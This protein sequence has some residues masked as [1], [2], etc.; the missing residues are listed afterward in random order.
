MI[1]FI[2]N[3]NMYVMV[4]LSMIKD[5]NERDKMF[6]FFSKFSIKGLIK[7][8]VMVSQSLQEI[9]TLILKPIKPRLAKGIIV[10]MCGSMAITS[11]NELIKELGRWSH[12][13]M[14]LFGGTERLEQLKL[15][16]FIDGF[17]KVC[18]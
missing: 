5:N 17:S 2:V 18:F 11:S 12:E 9:L 7:L 6:F 8:Y 15:S 14:N 16:L 13:Y 4:V 3:L 10:L 1:F